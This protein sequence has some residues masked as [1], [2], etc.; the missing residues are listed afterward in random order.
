MGVLLLCL[1]CKKQKKKVLLGSVGCLRHKK[2][3]G[4]N[5]WKMIKRKEVKD[6]GQN[7]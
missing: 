1:E 6:A 3:T 4:H 7:N 5:N 2:E